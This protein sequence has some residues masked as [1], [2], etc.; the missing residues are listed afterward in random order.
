MFATLLLSLL[1]CFHSF[2]P[3][4]ALTFLKFLQELSGSSCHPLLAQVERQRQ[5]GSS[6]HH[7]SFHTHLNSESTLCMSSRH[8]PS[9]ACCVLPL[10]HPAAALLRPE[11]WF[12]CRQGSSKSQVLFCSHTPR[13]SVTQGRKRAR[14]RRG[15]LAPS[16]P[17]PPVGFM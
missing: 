4:N 9:S 8:L 6:C 17:Q 14:M 2:S 12:T 13:L 5:P 10:L 3:K 15:N 7:E 11:Y 16:S 1:D